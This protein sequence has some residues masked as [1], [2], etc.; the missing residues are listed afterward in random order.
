MKRQL[1]WAFIACLCCLAN[2][3]SARTIVVTPPES[4]SSNQVIRQALEEAGRE[5]GKPVTIRLTPATYYFSRQES[6]KVRYY[7]SNTITKEDQADPL[8]HIAVLLKGLQNVTIDGCGST[9][10]MTGEMSSFVLDACRN[11]TLRN[12]NIDYLAP[13]QTEMTIVSDGGNYLIARVH[14]T[15]KYK[16]ENE[17]LYWSGDGWSFKGGI[18]QTYD[19]EQE[20]TWRSWSPMTGIVKVTELEPN[21]LCFVYK[22]KPAVV[23]GTVYQMRD[24]Y[25][26]EVCGFIRSCKD[27]RLEHVNFYYMGNFGI[28]GQFS[29]NIS[30][31]G[32]RFAPEPGSGRTNTGFADF[33][34][35]SG[36][37]GLLRLENCQFTGAH[38]DPINIH[39]THLKVT[40]YLADKNQVKVRFMHGQSYGFDAFFKGDDIEFVNAE[41]LLP[42]AKNRVKKAE[43]IDPYEMLLT[44]EKP[45]SPAIRNTEEVVI[46]NVTWTPEVVIRNNYFFHLPTRGILV[47]TRKPVRIE[48]NTFFRPQMSAILVADDALSWYESGRVEDVLISG[49]NFIE[50]KEPVILIAPENNKDEGCVHRN[51]RITGNSFKLDGSVA[52]DAKSVDGL[53]VSEN[54][55]KTKAK[56]E[57]GWTGIQTKQCTNV[58][59]QNNRYE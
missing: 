55:F 26:D 24:G 41:S 15:S 12:L 30:F 57:A 27:I 37:K 48:G 59:V 47:T 29:E 58:S 14:P 51:I 31:D 9:W 49:N 56:Q 32:V 39:G 11:I 3:I 46:E 45:V 52:V 6:D 19:P 10:M 18:A 53:I 16:I 44:L 21:L 25:R 17:N 54:L 36:C 38:D 43:L 8:K 28:V 22:K 50:C 20:I 5:K 23:P 1:Y 7:V 4:G 33:V 34:Q 2:T 42:M 35:M 40:E 13:T